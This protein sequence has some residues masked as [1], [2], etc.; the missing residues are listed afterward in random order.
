MQ[1]KEALLKP[2]RDFSEFSF[3]EKDFHFKMLSRF[4]DFPELSCAIGTHHFRVTKQEEKRESLL[5]RK[6]KLRHE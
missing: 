5:N 3:L 1:L 2:D 4:S 6:Q